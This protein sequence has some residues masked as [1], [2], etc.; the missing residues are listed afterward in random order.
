MKIVF[1]VYFLFLWF[2]CIYVQ[3]FFDAV[4]RQTSN[5]NIYQSWSIEY[6][7][8]IKGILR[9][10]TLNFDGW[11][12]VSCNPINVQFWLVY[13]ITENNCCLWL[14]TC[15]IQIYKSYPSS[16]KLTMHTWTEV[17]STWCDLPTRDR[18][19]LAVGHT[20]SAGRLEQPSSSMS[21]NLP[22]LNE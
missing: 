21:Q 1:I 15:F 4:R 17:P 6:Q 11:K 8:F 20:T 10:R 19:Y 2:L 13:K 5:R 3:Y 22:P 7:K 9:E 12:S 18:R 14:F 16:L